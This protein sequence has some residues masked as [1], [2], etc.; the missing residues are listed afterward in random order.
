MMDL[1]R[2]LPGYI[3]SQSGKA[4]EFCKRFDPCFE[5]RAP[6]DQMVGNQKHSAWGHLTEDGHVKHRMLELAAKST[7]RGLD[8]SLL[9]NPSAA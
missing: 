9:R 2:P 3:D 4:C 5:K 6:L 8:G 7:V 1:H